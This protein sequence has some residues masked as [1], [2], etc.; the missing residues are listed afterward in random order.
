M[1]RKI[2]YLGF[3]SLFFPLAALAASFDR[4]LYFGMAGDADVTRLQE[5]LRD[6][7]VYSGPITGSFFTLTREGVQK[8]QR[9]EK[10]EPSA[11]YFGPKTR[12]R[13]NELL[14]GKATPAAT[15]LPS[16][17]RE[18]Q[19]AFLRV[20]IA[21][22]TAQLASLQ[23]KMAEEAALA[24]VPA[25]E[26]SLP[27]ETAPVPVKVE[28][29]EVSGSTTGEFPIVE[30]NPTKLGEIKVT[31]TTSAD[32]LMANF[33]VLITDE[34][35]SAPNRNR[36]VYFMFKDGSSATD[37]TL[38]T[39]EFTFILAQP[40]PGQ[41]HISVITLPFNVTVKADGEKKATLW[42]DQFKYVKSGTLRLKTRKITAVNA[43]DIKG[44]FDFLLTR[45]APL[46]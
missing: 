19:I 4:D 5:F 41:P 14:S 22:L 29:I 16:G 8:F 30:T 11:G 31:N 3:I 33:E 17:S 7:E 13:A 20:K 37:T 38:S 45:E 28:K 34:M 46:F 9:K 42:V 23:K 25:E 21:E 12:V 44:G 36:K 43:T 15:V 40:S 10:I 6:Q 26:P 2:L 35:D 24:A 1:A 32:V 18:E 39:T 27:V